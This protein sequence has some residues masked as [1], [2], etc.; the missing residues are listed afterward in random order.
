M[1]SLELKMTIL[2][3][4]TIVL[5]AYNEFLALSNHKKYIINFAE[6]NPNIDLL[7]V[8]NGSKDKTFDIIKE[9]SGSNKNI[10]FLR[11][12]TNK[13]YGD[14]IY[15]GILFSKTKFVGWMASDFQ[16]TFED[17]LKGVSK[18]K[19][20]KSFVKSMRNKRGLLD[21]FFTKSMGLLCSVLFLYK[22]NDIN[23]TPTITNRDLFINEINIPKNFSFDF[24]AYYLAK[25]KNY[26]IIRFKLDYKDRKYG[27][28]TWNRSF[29][30]R[31]SLSLK[32]I[33]NILKIRLF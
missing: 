21:V 8:D 27:S 7:F 31:I 5:P 10:Y 33:I 32:T 30:S 26:E 11:I 17:F 4:I 16:V 24:F 15:K 9:I 20:D 14:G 1:M 28:S 2:D 19:N 6:K 12:K 3:N 13:G 22:F 25:K 18:I 29:F 23:S